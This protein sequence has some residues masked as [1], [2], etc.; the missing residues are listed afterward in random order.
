MYKK[1]IS[2]LIFLL[3]E[4]ESFLNFVFPFDVAKLFYRNDFDNPLE[5][6]DI[7]FFKKMEIIIRK[8]SEICLKYFRDSSAF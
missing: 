5:N 6:E 1:V 2:A 3:F 8:S 7:F 4:E